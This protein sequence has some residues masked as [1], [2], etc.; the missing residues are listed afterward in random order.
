MK[1]IK[2]SF[3][4]PV[5]LGFSIVCL[6]TLILYY[7]TG[8]LSNRIL[9]STYHSSLK[10]LL[11]YLRFIMH[12]FGHNGWEHFIGNIMYILLLGPILEEKY[13][14]FVIL[15]IIGLTALTT[16]L[17]NYIFFRQNMLC[18]ASGIVFA[19]IILVSFTNIKEGEIPLTVILIA[20]L[21]VGKEIYDGLLMRDSISQLSHIIGG[22]IGAATGFVLGRE[23]QEDTV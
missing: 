21:F 22:I 13:G 9:F 14:S 12:V 4:S 3:N 2:I 23:N 7:A 18:G 6:F 11:T 19:F 8:G 20:V 10:S 17:I 15:E 16:G 5:V 1:K